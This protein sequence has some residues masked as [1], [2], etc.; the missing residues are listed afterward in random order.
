MALT[1]KMGSSRGTDCISRRLIGRKLDVSQCDSGFGGG[2][3]GRDIIGAI[4]NEAA[5]DSPQHVSAPIKADRSSPRDTAPHWT[6]LWLDHTVSR[7]A[8]H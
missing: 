2:C 1:G 4:A 8:F 6:P 3:S 7:P 5:R